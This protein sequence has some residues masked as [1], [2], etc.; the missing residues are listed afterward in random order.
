MD[1][2]C[3]IR[4]YLKALQGRSVL[5][6]IRD[7]DSGQLLE[8]RAAAIVSAEAPPSV[9]AAK[10]NWCKARERLL[11]LKAEIDTELADLEQVR[12]RSVQATRARAELSAQETRLAQL[13]EEHRALEAQKTQSLTQLCTYAAGLAEYVANLNA[14]RKSGPSLFARI[15]RKERWCAWSRTNQPLLAA[16]ASALA[17]L[18][19]ANKSALKIRAALLKLEREIKKSKQGVAQAAVQADKCEA[20]VKEQRER[21][22]GRIVDDRLFSLGHEA[23]NLISP[24]LPD[25]LQRKREALFMAALALQRAFIDCVPDQLLHNLSVCMD[26][27][28]GRAPQDEAARESLPDLWSSLFL[29]VP[30]IS[31]SFASVERMFGE[32]APGSIGWLLIDEAGQAPPQAAVGAIMRAKRLIVV[33]NT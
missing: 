1:D 10:A 2:D 24:W 18:A 16:K 6:E 26:V 32:L 3:A 5:R 11:T 23:S 17:K 21:L 19:V 25:T 31:T 15:L 28:A 12:K 9:G 27:L 7:R 13:L 14:H 29:V 22:G 8:R 33:S 20:E 4:L 30:V